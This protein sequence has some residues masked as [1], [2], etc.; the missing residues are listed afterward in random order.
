MGKIGILSE[1]LTNKIA[2]GEVIERPSSVV[3]EL[4]ENA[5]DAKS[6]RIFVTAFEGGMDGIRVVDDGEGMAR[7][8]AL[9]AFQRYATSKI[10]TETD[11]LSIR[12]LGFRGEALPSI[13]AVSKVRLITQQDETTEGAEIEISAGEVKNLRTVGAPRGSSFEVRDL[14]Y[15][16][17]ARRKFLK[18]RQ[19]ELGHISRYLFEL[20]LSQYNI[21]FRLT[22]EKRQLLDAATCPSIDARILQLFGEAMIADSMVAAGTCPA[23]PGISVQAFLSRPPLKK[24]FRKA[25]HLFVNQRPIKSALLTHAIFE[26]YG[27]TLMKGEAPFFVLFLTVDPAEV[28][29]NAHPTKR[30][31]RFRNTTLIHQAVRDILRECLSSEG[32]FLVQRQKD[33]AASRDS[34]PQ[35]NTPVG[36]SENGRA[37]DWMAWP[38]GRQETH[39]GS[40]R[41]KGEA[42]GDLSDTSATLPGPLLKSLQ[43]SGEAQSLPFD[44]TLPSIR[45]LGQVY[46]TF[47]LAEI[48]GVL[49]LVDQ[50]TAHERILYEALLRDWESRRTSA[51]PSGEIQPFLIPRQI[52]LPL[53]KGAVLNDHLDLLEAIGCKI[54]PFGD[55]TF[56]VR[57]LPAL[58]AGIDLESLLHDI[59]D[60]LL[61]LGITAKSDQ[62]IRTIIASMACH[63]AVRANQTMTLPE[64]TSLLATYFQRKTPPTCPHGRPIVQTYPLS[65]LEKLFRRK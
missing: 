14:F 6:R 48:D 32:G 62:P 41:E 47:L 9:L 30:E 16:V 45:P 63:G 60:D 64:I 15:N 46:G 8:D 20:A 25:Q 51:T 27:N 4:V 37:N 34:L 44:E 40:V 7:D 42:Y 11:L 58:I 39:L 18:T 23:H 56:L 10:S 38:K 2:A 28:D 52:D 5:I 26:A 55:A 12:T 3:K 35:N 17:P 1:H 13:A 29:V 59:C 65:E 50:H 53:S 61:D 57:E 19:T 22:H 21:H 31:V 54:E 36:R 49:V 33:Q 43:T 24:N